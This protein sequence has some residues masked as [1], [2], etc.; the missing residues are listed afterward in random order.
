MNL[1]QQ[2]KSKTIRFNMVMGA[3]DMM[4]MNAVFLQ[5]LITIKEFAVSILTLKMIQTTGNIYY[6]NVTKEALDDLE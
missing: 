2:L 5:D 3:V 6:R 4:I 1:T